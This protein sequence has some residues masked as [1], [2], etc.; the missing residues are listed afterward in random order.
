MGA[1]YYGL[2]DLSRDEIT[3]AVERELGR[4]AR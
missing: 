1:H 2:Y 3:S 4:G